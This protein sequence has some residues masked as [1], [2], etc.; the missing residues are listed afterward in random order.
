MPDEIVLRVE[1]VSKGFCRSLNRSLA[2]G[3]QDIAREM[4]ALKRP[5]PGARPGEFLALDRVSFDLKQGESLGL[6]G[7][8]GSGKTTM[9]KIIS[10][11]LRPDSG[12]VT[13]RGRV[14]PLIALGAGFNPLLTGRENVSVNMS[15]LGVKARDIRRRF[16]SV[17]DFAEIGE[18]ID[19]PV[20]TYSSGMAAR[21]GFACAV[22]TEP[23]ILLVDEVLAVGDIRFRRKCYRRLGELTKNGTSFVLVSHAEGGNASFIKNAVYLYGG[24][25]KA[26]GPTSEVMA[27]Y[28][29]DL[30]NLDE[31][32]ATGAVDREGERGEGDVFIRRVYFQATEGTQL[33]ALKTGAPATAVIELEASRNARDI[34]F[35]V[36]IRTQLKEIMLSMWSNQDGSKIDVPAGRSRI[37]LHLPHV[38]LIPGRYEMFVGAHRD[39]FDIVDAVEWFPFQVE[40][41]QGTGQNL[42]YQERTWKLVS[43]HDEQWSRSVPITAEN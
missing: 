23:D 41:E 35:L 16:D 26:L 20:R 30:H 19:A 38:G 10:G 9:L 40:S 39:R 28:E 14:A 2:Y 32:Y 29:N 37:E 25:V 17:V 8:N 4:L 43:L 18:A 12:R 6:I 24:K 11:L 13:V 5:A 15:I 1:N 31:R 7:P 42:F 21:L 3:V 22:H 34:V 33:S 36:V 27:Q